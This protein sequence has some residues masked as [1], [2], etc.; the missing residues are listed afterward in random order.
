MTIG[1]KLPDIGTTIITDMSARAVEHG[2]FTL[3][4]QGGLGRAQMHIDHKVAAIPPPV[5]DHDR[6]NNAVLHFRFAKRDETLEQAAE[7]LCR[8]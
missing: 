2:T 5:F 7:I 8:T 3:S 6:V 4:E 1:S